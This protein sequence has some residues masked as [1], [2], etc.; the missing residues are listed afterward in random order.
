MA[1]R[2]NQNIRPNQN[3]CG[4]VIRD[5]FANP[6]RVHTAIQIAN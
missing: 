5:A 6:D 1:L 2:P 4:K 3:S